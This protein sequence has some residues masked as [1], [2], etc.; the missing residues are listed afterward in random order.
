MVYVQCYEGGRSRVIAE[1]VIRHQ[2]YSERVIGI[3]LAAIITEPLFLYKY[4]CADIIARLYGDGIVFASNN[5]RWRYLDC[6]LS[7]NEGQ[8]KAYCDWLSNS[9]K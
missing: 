6:H 2:H 5:R 4:I 7:I 8:C 3:T 9:Y 1:M